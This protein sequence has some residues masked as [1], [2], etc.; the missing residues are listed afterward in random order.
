V[1]RWVVVLEG[2][3]S[4]TVQKGR[5]IVQRTVRGNMS[6]GLGECPDPVIADTRVHSKRRVVCRV[7]SG[8]GSR[9]VG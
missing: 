3:M 5:E 6:R 1:D 4:C 8:T 2:E 7:Y 9:D